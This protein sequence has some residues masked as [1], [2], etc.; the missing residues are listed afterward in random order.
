MGGGS[1][2][3]RETF[4]I[5]VVLSLLSRWTVG[6]LDKLVAVVRNYLDHLFD[7]VFMVKDVLSKIEHDLE[8]RIQDCHDPQLF[9]RHL[10]LPDRLLRYIT[11][12]S[13]RPVTLVKAYVSTV[14]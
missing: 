2:R 4:E 6:L 10:I 8:W 14:G 9:C 5:D 12:S 7:V 3:R 13:L 11:V 1:Y